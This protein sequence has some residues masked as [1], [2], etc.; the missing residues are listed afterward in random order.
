MHIVINISQLHHGKKCRKKDRSK[1]RKGHNSCDLSPYSLAGQQ[2]VLIHYEDLAGEVSSSLLKQV[3]EIQR[4]KEFRC[5]QR[6]KR[7][8]KWA[9]GLWICKMNERNRRKREREKRERREREKETE[10]LSHWPLSHSTGAGRR[11]CS[12]SR[13]PCS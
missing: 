8:I 4:V 2:V 5:S 11:V 6:H 13:D 10:R 3:S 12:V 9:R 7:K 1:E